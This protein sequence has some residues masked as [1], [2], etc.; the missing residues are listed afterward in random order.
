MIKKFKYE[1]IVFFLII[2]FVIL[3]SKIENNI[4]VGIE[5]YIGDGVETSKNKNLKNFFVNITDIGSSLWF[6]ILSSFCFVFCYFLKKINISGE[7]LFDK[8]KNVSLLLF[9]ATATTGVLTQLLKHFFGR[10]RPNHYDESLSLGFGFFNFESSFHSFPSG[11]SSTIFVVALVFSLLT[12]RIK[13]FYLIIAAIIALSRVFV[14]AHYL[15]DILGGVV[16]AYVGFK[17][18]FYMFSKI[19]KSKKENYKLLVNENNF[20]LSFFIFFIC[21]FLVT[22][23]SSIDIYISNLFYHEKNF[24]I[25]GFHFISIFTRKIFLSLLVIYIFIIPFISKYRPVQIIYFNY[26]FGLKEILFLWL[27]NMFNLIVVVNLL[28]KNIWG[29]ARPNDISN[30]G[31][32]EVFTAWYNISDACQTNCSFVSGDASVGFS[33]ITLYLITKKNNFFWASLLF[34][35]YLGVIRILEGGHFLSDVLLSGFIIF[36]LSL[37]EIKIFK[38]LVKNE[39]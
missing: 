33:L 29:R 7:L 9:T 10:P 6:F 22:I 12:P 13:Y 37:I 38:K 19:T 36:S 27:A 34:G 23:G 24:L 3:F 18:S 1:V 35:F 8:I 15:S 5:N 2:L 30:F 11:H 14:G 31:G 39:I 26:G 32:N 21:I 4:S 17:L 25:Q 20:I 28:L 16:V